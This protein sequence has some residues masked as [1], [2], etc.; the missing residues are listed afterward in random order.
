MKSVDQE[1]RAVQAYP[2]FAESNPFGVVIQ[3]RMNQINTHKVYLRSVPHFD[4]ELRYVVAEANGAD[5]VRYERVNGKFTKMA[6]T[7]RDANSRQ[8]FEGAREEAKDFAICEYPVFYVPKASK[9]WAERAGVILPH[10]QH[11]WKCV[12][13]TDGKRPTVRVYKKIDGVSSVCNE[14]TVGGEIYNLV[15][16]NEL[17]LTAKN[18]DR[19]GDLG[20]FMN[21]PQGLLM[22]MGWKIQTCGQGKQGDVMEA[23]LGELQYLQQEYWKLGG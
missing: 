1:A 21:D 8:S 5:M 18:H 7:F 12:T 4:P 20:A 19:L 17:I 10:F 11:S 16:M 6:T 2:G 22:E 3:I 13:L 15:R 9:I 14:M 23:K